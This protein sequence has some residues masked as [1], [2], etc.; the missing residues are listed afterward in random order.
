M[1][2]GFVAILGRP[3]VGKSTL[4]NA[5]LSKKVSIVTPRA[6]T[7]RDDVMGVYNEKDLQIVFV[8]T[9]GLF[10]GKEA[11]DAH[12]NKEARSAMK[13]A[14]VLV[15]LLDASCPDFTE[16]DK[17]IGT[18]NKQTPLVLVLNKIDLVTL[19]AATAAQKHFEEAFPKAEILQMSALTNYGLKELKEAV[20]AHLSEGP[21]YYPTDALTDKDHS[22]IAKEVV[23]EELLHFLK[24][25]VPHQCAVVIDEYKEKDG[26]A[27]I[28]GTVY[29]EKET[30]V[31]IVIGKAGTMIKKISMSAR[32]ELERMWGKHVTLVL[33]VRYEPDWRNN[34]NKLQKLG[35]G[36]SKGDDD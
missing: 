11:L 21:A 31:G 16:D 36:E 34:P 24:E 13:G 6:Q 19:P 3:N 15:Y 9:P 20:V 32:R 8:D 14:E 33:L 12:M 10:E 28:H 7:T 27:I 4:I 25:E 30:Q 5:L 2:S 35:Y 22:F 23:R 29:V 1:K 26:A 17:I 18:L